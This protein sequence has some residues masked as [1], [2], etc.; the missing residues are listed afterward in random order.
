MASACSIRV[1]NLKVRIA[2]ALL[3]L[4]TGW[5]RGTTL[6]KHSTGVTWRSLNKMVT[7][8]AL[9]VLLRKSGPK[10]T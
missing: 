4:S 10:L 2:E 9:G 6:A 7:S 1:L 8:C 5:Q 3:N